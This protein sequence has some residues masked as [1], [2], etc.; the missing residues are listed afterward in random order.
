MPARVTRNPRPHE[1]PH[2]N[3]WYLNTVRPLWLL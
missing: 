1:G 3:E 2:I